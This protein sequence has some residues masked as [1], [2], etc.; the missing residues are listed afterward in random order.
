MVVNINPPIVWKWSLESQGYLGKSHG[1][2]FAW[3]LKQ[4]FSCVKT[5]DVFFSYAASLGQNHAWPRR[6]VSPPLYQTRINVVKNRNTWPILGKISLWNI[7]PTPDTPGVWISN[8]PTLGQKM[9]TWTWGNVGKYS[10]SMEHFGYCTWVLFIPGTQF[11]ETTI[12][13]IK[14]WNHPI[15]TSIYKWLFWVPGSYPQNH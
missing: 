1:W 12:F 3:P 8:L 10:H 11:G 4:H 5:L 15:E 6:W 7:L 2:N 9:A 13:Y 14:I